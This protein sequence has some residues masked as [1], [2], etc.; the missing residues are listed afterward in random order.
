MCLTIKRIKHLTLKPKKAKKDI[1]VY[2]L[3]R[4]YISLKNGMY[5]TPFTSC[6][7][8]IKKP[9]ICNRLD[10]PHLCS[11]NKE[12]LIIFGIHTYKNIRLIKKKYNISFISKCSLVVFKCIIPKGTL[13]WVGKNGEYAS[14]RIEFVKQIY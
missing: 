8:D 2:K 7:V 4:S 13:Y 11:N 10:T 12:Y 6:I 3:L 1:I 5:Y 9:L 14:E